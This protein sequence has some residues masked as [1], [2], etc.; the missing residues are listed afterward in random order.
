[1]ITNNFEIE[2]NTSIDK[3]W[4]ALTNS[5]EFNKWMKTVKVQTEWKQ[6][7]DIT[8]TCYDE[9]D[10]VMQWEGMDMIWNGI[11]ETIEENKELTCIYPTKRTGLEKESYFLEKLSDSKTKLSQ[12]QILISQAVA[13]GYKD[14]TAQTLELLKKHLENPL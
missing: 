11:I 9:N 7:A 8:Y 2:V 1:M 12:I 10:K 3:I 5:T 13:D 6:G 4:L 14:G